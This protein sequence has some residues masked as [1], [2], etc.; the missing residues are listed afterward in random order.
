V[1]RCWAHSP[2]VQRC[3]LEGGHDGNHSITTRW[4]DEESLT[5]EGQRAVV[6]ATPIHTSTLIDQ[7]FTEPVQTLDKC[8]SCG[9]TKAQHSEE[10]EGGDVM[11]AKHQCRAFLP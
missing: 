5:F 1:S 6:E 8:F 3:D 10:L 11:C 7:A 2:E 4:A 9:C